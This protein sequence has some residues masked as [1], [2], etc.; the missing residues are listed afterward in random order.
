MDIYFA[1]K[2]QSTDEVLMAMLTR[3]EFE[4]FEENEDHFIA[5]IREA[6]FD[7]ETR[8][9]VAAV[10]DQFSAPFT[11]EKLE[12]QNWNAL[13]EASFQPVIV[14]DFCQIRADFHPPVAGMKYDLVINPK[15]AFGTGHH[16]TTHMM[17]QRMAAIDFNLKTVFD[18]GCGTGILAILASKLGATHTDAIDIEHESYMNTIENCAINEV[19]NVQAYEGDLNAVPEKK[20]DVILANINRNILVKYARQLTAKLNDTGHLLLSGVLA[21][22]KNSVI[23]TYENQGLHV[24]KESAMDGWVCVL[25][26]KMEAGSH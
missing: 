21:E 3:F 19:F 7:E 11:I 10:L 8:T 2:V 25:L 23:S 1:V 24:L 22:D 16:A 9:E 6:Y 20:Y 26:S 18:F 13:W 15:M 4:S 17:I 12:P 5:Y 14:E